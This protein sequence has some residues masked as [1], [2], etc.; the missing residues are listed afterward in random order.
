MRWNESEKLYDFI[1]FLILQ[2]ALLINS[3]HDLIHI[4]HYSSQIYQSQKSS[5][6]KRKCSIP[7]KNLRHRHKA[8][9]KLQNKNP[10]LPFGK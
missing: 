7:P 9:K 2:T 6:P 3:T 1:F 8:I 4:P 10:A 5:R